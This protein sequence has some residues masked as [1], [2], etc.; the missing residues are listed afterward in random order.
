MIMY[1]YSSLCTYAFST[2]D[3]IYVFEVVAL[4]TCDTL[5]A[6]WEVYRNVPA[7]CTPPVDG[8]RRRAFCL[9]HLCVN[10]YVVAV[11]GSEP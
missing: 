6:C 5:T 3:A 9:S 7:W 2:C 1:P 4:S 10:Q 8:Y 11:C